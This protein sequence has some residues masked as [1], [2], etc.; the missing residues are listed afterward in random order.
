MNETDT[1]FSRNFPDKKNHMVAYFSAEYG[2]NEVLPIYSGGL[3][4]LSGDHC[5]SASDLG[6]PFTAI[7][8]FYKQ[9]YFSQHINADGWQETIF[10]DLNTS[11]L[12][13]RPALDQNGSQIT[14]EVELPGRIVF[15][16]IWYVQI[17]RVKLYLMDTDHEHNNP[18]D[19]ALTARLYGGDQETR[20]QQEIFS[21][22]FWVLDT[23]GIKPTVFHMNEG[24]SAFL[25]LE[26]IRK[27]VQNQNLRFDKLKSCIISVVFTTPT[28]VPAG[29]D[30]FLWR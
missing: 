12:P 10:T 9:G 6:L 21:L 4:V 22:W 23:L 2:L 17:G 5:K 25:G 15:A 14:I 3:G 8:L 20:I 24:H 30:V 7:G 13:I 11:N 1:W 16:K 19:R 29:N 18:N 28:P 27:L 26:L